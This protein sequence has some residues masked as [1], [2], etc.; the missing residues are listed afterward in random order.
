MPTARTSRIPRLAPWLALPMLALAFLAAVWLSGL[1]LRGAR[2]DLT[3]HRLYT[4]SDGT[5][6]ILGKLQAPVKLTVFY[7]ERA[8]AGQPQFRVYAQRVRELLEE[9]AAKSKGRLTL[10]FVDPEPFTDAE[11]LLFVRGVG[12]RTVQLLAEQGYRSVDDIMKEDEDKLAIKT[13]LGIKKARA[14]KQ[15]AEY[16]L[17][18]EWRAIDA[19]RKAAAAAALAAQKAETPDA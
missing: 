5:V 8:A 3:E 1:F 6:R 16:F 10:D 2:L 15:G 18:N 12:E 14:L 17:Q 9:V 13:G 19:A 4:L 7:S 11:K